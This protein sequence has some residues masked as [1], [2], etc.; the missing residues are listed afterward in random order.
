LFGQIEAE[1]EWQTPEGQRVFTEDRTY[2]FFVGNA[3]ERMTDQ[4]NVFKFNDMDVKFADTKEG[5][6]IH[7]ADT[8]T[9]QIASEWSF[10]SSPPKISMK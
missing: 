2:T 7:K 9:A 1:I 8:K 10:Y 6:I 4:T 5:G 3:D